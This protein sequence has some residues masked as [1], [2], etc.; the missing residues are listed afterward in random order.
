MLK[1]EDFLDFMIFNRYAAFPNI[2]ETSDN[3]I[4]F[5]SLVDLDQ[6]FLVFSYIGFG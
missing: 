5:Y 4:F 6:I 3:K 1:S 2:A